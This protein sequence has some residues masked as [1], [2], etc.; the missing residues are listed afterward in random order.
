MR[1]T[2]KE[3]RKL[4]G[5]NAEAHVDYVCDLI[6]AKC[7]RDSRTQLRLDDAFWV[8]GGYKNTLEWQK[9][10]KILQELGYEVQFVY[11]EKNQFVDMY[12]LVEW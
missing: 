10:V 11:E 9:A 1:L 3:A 6:K 2:A 5:M 7:N 4:S 8:N 12:T